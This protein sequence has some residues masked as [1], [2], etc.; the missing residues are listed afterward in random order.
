LLVDI[1]LI[2]GVV[3]VLPAVAGATATAAI[4]PAPAPTV[5]ARATDLF[6]GL[7]QSLLPDVE[8]LVV[9]R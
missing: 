2:V 8:R 5:S 6:K 7:M 9:S 3:A 4:A 1:S